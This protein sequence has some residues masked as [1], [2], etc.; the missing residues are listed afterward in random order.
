MSP[1]SLSTALW[2]SRNRL[3]MSW[4]KTPLYLEQDAQE[5]LMG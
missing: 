5:D 3:L 1:I 2:T 4:V